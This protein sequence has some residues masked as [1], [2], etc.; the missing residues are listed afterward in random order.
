MR[1]LARLRPASG[2][3]AQAHPQTPSI[4]SNIRCLAAQSTSNSSTSRTFSTSQ[5][6]PLRSSRAQCQKEEEAP[7]VDVVA[8]AVPVETYAPEST[9][10]LPPEPEWAPHADSVP[11]PNYKPATSLDQLQEVGGLEGWWEVE[12]HW[13]G[14]KPAFTPF[15]AG[16]HKIWDPKLL[17]GIARRAVA[18]ALVVREAVEQG[19]EVPRTWAV[20]DKDA[21]VRAMTLKIEVD[22][23]REPKVRSNVEAKA[24]LEDIART[25]EVAPP[26][27]Q[28]VE[29]S[30]LVAGMNA[31]ETARVLEIAG[32]QWKD[33]ALTDLKFKFMV[34]K[35]IQQLSGHILT[36]HK[37][38]GKG[39]VESLVKSLIERP[40]PKKL[41][42]E[43]KMNSQLLDLPNV[44][45]H[46]RRHTRV[47][48]H[49]AAGR[50]KVIVRELEKRD[51][52]V[53]GDGKYGRSVE[54]S[55]IMGGT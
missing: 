11:D 21:A 8:E 29:G 36:D 55:W 13:N 4:A 23:E 53:L 27:T 19:F 52:P 54:R 17:E 12:E 5:P 14:T 2:F 25:E 28:Q 37:Y 10:V 15:F 24:V 40:R 16:S 47:D 38:W 35:R 48:K 33:I 1:R 3:L 45:V 43:L 26:L 44:T 9:F 31:A 18:E 39:H 22:D 30:D 6:R 51:L 34:T 49:K 46:D 41:A 32:R 42:D 20:G 50:W 7:A